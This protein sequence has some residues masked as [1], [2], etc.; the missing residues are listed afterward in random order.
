VAKV[1][2]GMNLG[3]IL[4]APIG[5]FIGHNL[6]WRATFMAVAAVSVAALLLVLRFVPAQPAAATGSV[7]GELR[8][9]SAPPPN[10]GFRART[11]RAPDY[12]DPLRRPRR[13]TMHDT[14]N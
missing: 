6:G 8:V 3:I 10:R 1:A 2:L 9:S 5:T 12:L 13:N 7:F 4:G 11:L 14:A